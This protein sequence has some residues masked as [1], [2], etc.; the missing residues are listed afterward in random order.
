MPINRA[1]IQNRIKV[2]AMMLLVASL[3][4]SLTLNNIAIAL[5]A[6]SWIAES[7]LTSKL[8]RLKQQHLFLYFISFYVVSIVGLIYTENIKQGSF[9]LEKKVTLLLFPLIFCSSNPVRREDVRLVFKAF[10]V[11]CTLAALVCYG[12]A[13]YKNYTE[14]HTPIYLFNAIF[15]DIHLAGRYEYFNYWYFT[16]GLFAEPIDMHPVY[17][18]MY[19]VFSSCLGVWLWM[20]KSGYRGRINKWLILLLGF[21]F[22]TIVLLSSRTQVA[23]SLL[24]SIGFVLY[25]AHRRQRLFTG[26]AIVGSAVIIVLGL[27]FINPV[28][29]DRF[30]RSGMPGALNDESNFGGWQLRESKWKYSLEA[31]AQNPVIGTGTGDAQDVLQ[32]IYKKHSF[33]EG[34]ENSFNPHN[35]LLQAALELGLVGLLAFVVALLVP[36]IRSIQQHAWL[37]L[38]FISLFFLS[39]QT[40]SMLEANKGIVFYAFFNSFLAF[41]FLMEP[42][43]EATI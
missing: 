5:L 26:I 37:Y 1:Y 28:S 24:I 35:Q 3:P 31:I 18:A 21:N 39:C 42:H 32:E 17:F 40:E 30:F 41:H 9:E 27:I 13:I 12:N 20:E 23:L 33:T 14:G 25:Y 36:A 15:N 38:I 22:I 6:V 7:S 11:A 16:Y 4:F 43:A 19:L 34:Y 8:S 10:I 29:R 2:F